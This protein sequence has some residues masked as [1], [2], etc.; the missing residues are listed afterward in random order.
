MVGAM[1]QGSVIVDLAAENGGN[2]EL[3][4][5]GEIYKHAGINI[6]GVSIRRTILY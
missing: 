3:T 5:P 1:K 2:C 4:R 6:I